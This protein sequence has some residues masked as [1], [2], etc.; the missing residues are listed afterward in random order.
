MANHLT[1]AQG[2]VHP[3]THVGQLLKPV[4]LSEDQ[5]EL[6][7]FE[8]ELTRDAF[9][10]KKGDIV[11]V[12]LDLFGSSETGEPSIMVNSSYNVVQLLVGPVAWDANSM[13]RLLGPAPSTEES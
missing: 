3:Q 8:A 4:G 10:Q 2:G 12:Q 9:G 1:T 6:L 13:Q 11:K 7:D 5:M